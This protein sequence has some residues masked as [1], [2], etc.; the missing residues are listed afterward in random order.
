MYVSYVG[1][2]EVPFGG[3]NFFPTLAI[4]IFSSSYFSSAVYFRSVTIDNLV[5][6]KY[7]QKRFIASIVN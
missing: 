2:A 3:V 1:V 7:N 4:L 6:R 5:N